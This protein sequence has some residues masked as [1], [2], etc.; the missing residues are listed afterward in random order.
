MAKDVAF[1]A[2]VPPEYPTRCTP[3]GPS[4]SEAAMNPPLFQAAVYPTLT[5]ILPA[6]TTQ[7][8]FLATS[9]TIIVRQQ[10]G[11]HRWSRRFPRPQI[12]VLPQQ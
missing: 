11:K 8:C 3:C 12:A 4:V 9:K 10:T 7:L 6:P 1:M 2:S 5:M